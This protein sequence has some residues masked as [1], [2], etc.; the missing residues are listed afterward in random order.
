LS[1]KILLSIFAKMPTSD[2]QNTG[3]TPTV[4]QTQDP[5]TTND[6]NQTSAFDFSL[7]LPDSFPAASNTVAEETSV[8]EQQTFPSAEEPVSENV[9]TVEEVSA[10][11]DTGMDFLHEEPVAQ[12]E[13]SSLEESA[14]VALGPSQEDIVS[15]EEMPLPS[16][17]FS[18]EQEDTMPSYSSEPTQMVSDAVEENSVQA[19]SQESVPASLQMPPEL[20]TSFVQKEEESQTLT[21]VSSGE[22]DVNIPST[23]VQPQ[24]SVQTSASFVSQ[25]PAPEPVAS[26]SA[27]EPVMQDPFEAMRTSLNQNLTPEPVVQASTPVSQSLET[28]VAQTVSSASEKP[29]GMLSLDEMIA[30][31][32][33]AP[34]PTMNLDAMMGTSAPVVANPLSNPVAYPSITQ[35]QPAQNKVSALVA[36][37]GVFALIVAV[38]FMAFL[39]YP[40]E[41][42]KMF[43][44]GGGEVP[45]MQMAQLTGEQEHGAAELTGEVMTGSTADD[46][47]DISETEESADLGEVTIDEKQAETSDDVQE[48]VLGD[49]SS[50]AEE[51]TTEIKSEESQNSTVISGNTS[52]DP[53]DALGAVEGIVG[54]VSANE[55]L[56]QQVENFKLKA[57]QIADAGKAQ[58]NRM[59]LK[60]GIY[61]VNQVKKVQD[62]LANGQK[63][64]ISEWNALKSELELSLA[65]AQNDGN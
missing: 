45:A 26:Y 14:E 22:E 38:G 60:Y 57:Q 11:V 48:V 46:A 64:S 47:T 55:T 25:I 12:E 30:Q 9:P 39:K 4:G 27:P 23:F 41:I 63:M 13:D 65:K 15:V 56:T 6:Q 61:V 2:N 62:D 7:D 32:V 3:F 18:L 43:G 28:P 52:S 10:P 31:P 21:S 8:P 35:P 42:Q 44:L 16:S 19:T 20:P 36:V 59:M 40:D 51:S 58:G 24:E 49:A 54:E 53:V 1:E 29:M 5:V 33:A 17:D 50:D 34:A 37:F